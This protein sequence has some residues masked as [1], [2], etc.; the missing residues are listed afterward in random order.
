[1]TSAAKENF[2]ERFSDASAR[3]NAALAYTTI[4]G[5]I[6]DNTYGPGMTVTVQE[7]VEELKMSRTPIRD[8]LIRLEQERFVEI[9]PRYGF[10][11]LP[12]RPDEM[13]NI[14]QLVA[15]LECIAIQLIMERGLKTS[16]RD[17]LRAAGKGMKKALVADD[18]DA[19]SVADAAF[20]RMLV[21]FCGNP[22]LRQAA[23]D[24]TEQIFRARD[25]TLRLR[26][27]PVQSTESHWETIEAMAAGDAERASRVHWQQRGRSS[28]ELTEILSRLNIRQL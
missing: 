24:Q 2:L 17:E 12:L 10:R 11:V 8:A 15:G 21:D 1:M 4:K 16:E 5:R 6:L 9:T 25:L 22:V 19:W 18:L 28:R 27:K 13:L 26:R 7:I 14:Y 3:T 23:L 20:H